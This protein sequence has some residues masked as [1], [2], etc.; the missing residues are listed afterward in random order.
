MAKVIITIED[1]KDGRVKCV[2]NPTFQ[3]MIELHAAKKGLEAS[4][5]YAICA[6]SAIREASKVGAPFQAI[7]DSFKKEK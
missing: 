3:E 4:H 6:M 5:G 7:V 1:G 2:S